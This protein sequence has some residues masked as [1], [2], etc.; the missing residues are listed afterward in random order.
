VRVLVR[1]VV[2]AAEELVHGAAEEIARLVVA[3]GVLGGGLLV[4]SGRPLGIL[5]ARPGISGRLGAGRRRVSVGRNVVRQGRGCRLRIRR[6]A[7]LPDRQRR[8]IGG[9]LL[10]STGLPGR[11][12]RSAGLPGRLLRSAGLPGR[13]RSIGAGGLAL[14]CVA[15][16]SGA[17]SVGARAR[18]VRVAGRDRD[19][20]ARHAGR[21]RRSVARILPLRRDRRVAARCGAVW[22]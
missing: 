16:L 1:V 4:G 20:D 12:L 7:V 14:R 10:R 17:R 6:R 11:L 8:G 22:G 2:A 3:G 15:V 13:R 5:L 21:D 19:V 9:R 18:A